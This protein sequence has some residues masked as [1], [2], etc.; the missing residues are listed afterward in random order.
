LA[1]A[2]AVAAT[3]L[4]I[5]STA[6]AD[7]SREVEVF[8]HAP[9]PGHPFGVLVHDG[10]VLVSTSAGVPTYANSMGERVFRFSSTG[11]LLKSS[12]VDTGANSQMG[13]GGFGV[14]RANRVYLADMNGLI[15]R[16]EGADATDVWASAPLPYSGGGWR[17]SMWNDIDFTSDGTAYITDG[18]PAGRIWRVT[19]DGKLSLWFNDTRLSFAGPFQAQ[20]SA[21]E[22]YLYFAAVASFSPDRFAAG[23]VYRIPLKDQPTAS[24]LEELHRFPPEP[25]DVAHGASPTMGPYGGAMTNGLSIGRSGRLYVSVSG[26]DQLAVLNPDGSLIKL[27]SSPLFHYPVYSTF[28]GD[29]LLVANQDAQAMDNVSDDGSGWTIVSVNV[30]DTGIPAFPT[31]SGRAADATAIATTSAMRPHGT[32]GIARSGSS[33]QSTIGFGAGLLALGFALV[34]VTRKTRA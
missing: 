20:V 25:G 13:L 21:D 23:S 19:P 22:M 32:D 24:D 2:A 9:S 29:R 1:L 6:S 10:E 18:F 17:T 7:N 30:G 4:A 11:K 5:A 3:L 16:V 8:A 14:D 33:A 27:I 31:G 26:R 12:V 34:A 15:R 28:F